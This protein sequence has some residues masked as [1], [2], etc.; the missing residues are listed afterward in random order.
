MPS[1]RRPPPPPPKENSEPPPPPLPSRVVANGSRQDSPLSNARTVPTSRGKAIQ[2]VSL[3]HEDDT[4][5]QPSSPPNSGFSTAAK[6]GHFNSFPPRQSVA[7]DENCEV[8]WSDEDWDEDDEP[9]VEPPTHTAD[10]TY[11]IPEGGDGVMLQ[12]DEYN[13]PDDAHESTKKTH[14]L[15]TAIPQTARQDFTKQLSATINKFPKKSVSDSRENKTNMTEVKP[16]VINRPIPP[17]T[18]PSNMDKPIP[19]K[20]KPSSNVDKPVPNPKPVTKPPEPILR[21]W[22]L[23]IEKHVFSPCQTDDNAGAG[24]DSAVCS[25]S[26]EVQNNSPGN[27]PQNKFRIQV[28][29]SLHDSFQDIMLKKRSQVDTPQPIVQDAI[30]DDGSSDVLSGYD[31]FHG[32]LDR[33]EASRRVKQLSENGTFLIRASKSDGTNTSHPYTLVVTLDHT[34]YNLIVRQRQDNRYAIGTYKSDEVSF[35]T[36]PDLV[37]HHKENNIK[38]SKGGAV[39]LSR[40]P[41]KF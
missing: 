14:Q 28:L 21:K 19:P 10:D 30:Y 13:L 16:S 37:D 17:P 18:K 7:S 39:K 4:Y 36:V 24:S 23:S 2:P 32:E 25:S 41:Q 12:P 26:S 9:L 29:P 40:T 22:P 34:V 15:P 3:T 33:D 8:G 27:Q 20:M 1:D 5:E 31:W 35:P 6:G 11:L 38:L